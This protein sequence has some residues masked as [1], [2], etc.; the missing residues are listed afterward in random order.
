MNNTR[1][2]ERR[3]TGY[4][5]YSMNHKLLYE[6][7]IQKAKQRARVSG[8]SELHHIIPKSLGGS[9]SNNN[10]V[11]LT[12]R[13]H[14]LCHY[15]L[16]KMYKEHSTEWYKMNNAFMMMMK[17]GHNS[18]RYFNSRLYESLKINFSKIASF[19]QTGDKNSNFGLKWICNIGDRKNI[20][21]PKDDPVPEGWLPGRVV[22]WSTVDTF[23][24]KIYKCRFC[25]SIFLRTGSEIFCSTTCH[26]LD[27]KQM[28]KNKL[29]LDKLKQI[30]SKYTIVY[31]KI[32][33]NILFIRDA[34]ANGISKNMILLHIKCN[35][36]GANYK[37]LDKIFNSVGI[38]LGYEPG[39]R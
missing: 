28:H 27:K 8:Y 26:V 37:T 3:N 19:N 16:A 6:N 25:D 13:E 21:I 23:T 22:D 5:K 36:S 30:S 24:G 10:L 2:Y 20:K 35:G 12:A 17:A 4:D 15:C 9:N 7:I 34:M 1:R 38:P 31:G 29:P 32:F 39:E 14:F 18:K 11:R 33:D